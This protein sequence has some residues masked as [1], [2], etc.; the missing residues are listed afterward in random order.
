[1]EHHQAIRGGRGRTIVLTG[2]LI[3]LALT[4]RCLPESHAQM[5]YSGGFTPSRRDNENGTPQTTVPK[6]KTPAAPKL[7]RDY[8]PDSDFS[9]LSIPSRNPGDIASS[10]SARTLYGVSTTDLPWNR[11]GFK[12]YDEPLR[13]PRDTSFSKPKKYTLEVSILSPAAP[14]EQPETA[15]L[16][17]HLPETAVFWVEGTPTRSTGR[18][19]YF[20]SPPLLSGRKYKYTVRVAW[21]EDSQWVSQT[22]TIPV[23]AGLIQAIYLQPF[24]ENARK[25]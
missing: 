6:L 22:Q 1:M 9:Y 7:P 13:I 15:M 24:G 8:F 16:I 11:T 18:T 19:R 25:Q 17:A 20:R 4:E 21:I 14:A 2:S 23:Q 3:L 10:A 12:D 5:R